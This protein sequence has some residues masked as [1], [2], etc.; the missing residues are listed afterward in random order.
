MSRLVETRCLCGDRRDDCNSSM[1]VDSPVVDSPRTEGLSIR[2]LPICRSA[3]PLSGSL[4]DH[5]HY[6]PI[7]ARSHARSQSVGGGSPLSICRGT[8]AGNQAQS[9]RAIWIYLNE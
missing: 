2:T 5:A 6:R 1:T 8:S 7:S 4:L 3:L 9:L